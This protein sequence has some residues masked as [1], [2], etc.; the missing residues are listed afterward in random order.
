MRALSLHGGGAQGIMVI[1]YLER[2]EHM[3][4]IE[5]RGARLGLFIYTLGSVVNSS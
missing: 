5:A 1:V 4:R 3:L 2:K